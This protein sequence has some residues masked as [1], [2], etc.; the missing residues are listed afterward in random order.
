[1]RILIIHECDIRFAAFRYLNELVRKLQDRGDRVAV[2]CPHE[3]HFRLAGGAAPAFE[4]IPMAFEGPFLSRAAKRRIVEFAPDIVHPWNARQL[5][6]RAALEAVVATSAKLV[7]HYEDPEE[8]ILDHASAVVKA[9]NCLR[10]VNKPKLTGE[11]VE[12]FLREL[13]W[14]WI[15]STLGAPQAWNVV[16]PLFYALL[17]HLASAFTAIWHPLAALL[18]E[19]FDKPVALVPYG[20]DFAEP[21]QPRARRAG[22]IREELDLPPGCFVFLR[23]GTVYG[24]AHDQEILLAGFDRHRR[25][26]PESRLVICGRD[27][28]PATT[29]RVVHSLGLDEV[30]RTVG[31]LEDERFDALLADSDAAICPGHPDDFNHYRLSLKIISYMIERKPMICYASGIGGDLQDGRDALLLTEY[32]PAKVAELMDRLASDGALRCSLAQN[33]NQLARQWFDAGTLATRL[34]ALYERVLDP[35]AGAGQKDGL[36]PYL[37]M[38][39]IELFRHLQAGKVPADLKDEVQRLLGQ[40]LEAKGT[41]TSMYNLAT[42]LAREGRADEARTLLGQIVELA[43]PASRELA[44]KALYKLA[45]F[46]NDPIEAADLLSRCL[47]LYPEHRSARALLQRQHLADPLSRMQALLLVS[48]LAARGARYA[49]Y[50]PGELTARL[51]DILPRSGLPLPVAVLD[52]AAEGGA[53]LGGCRVVQ[54]KRLAAKAVDE[55]LLGQTPA[56]Q[57]GMVSL[58]RAGRQ[59][60]VVDVRD[61]PPDLNGSSKGMVAPTTVFHCSPHRAAS[62]WIRRLLSSPRVAAATGMTYFHY[63]EQWYGGLDPR[64]V[65]ERFFS[66]AFPTGAICGPMFVSVQGLRSIP[67]PR[68]WRAF[69]V[70]RDPRDLL[71]SLYFSDRYSHRLMG[72]LAE[73]RGR[74]GRLSVP[75]GIGLL[76]RE[77][78]TVGYFD[79]IRSWLDVPPGDPNILLVRYEELTGEA[80]VLAFRRLFDHLR[81]AVADGDLCQLL[82]ENSFEA[83]TGRTQ[84]QE[85]IYAHL[86]RGVP[87]D[88]RVYFDGECRRLFAEAAGD[89]PQAMGYE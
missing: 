40:S 18:E 71:V 7:V 64:P 67:K 63:E 80:G 10:W 47:Q 53:R 8:L 37:G 56:P 66:E 13:N 62:Q 1:M 26:F 84:G 22:R 54:P 36:G 12:A 70:L 61:L 30:V 24:H 57:G 33:A 9:S 41:L 5:E 88:W 38:E 76:I 42:L 25:N 39:S 55:V 73:L 11:D 83:L 68:E 27:Q 19:R 20:V 58:G 65:R 31:Y 85:D 81:L 59:V 28:E 44:G 50:G 75:E 2:L 14:P 43:G 6:A 16:H 48:R 72:N 79:A 52:G 77:W 23:A 4:T 69:Y 34:H 78:Q 21:P 86:R 60:R 87:G 49:I 3:D 32:S 17:N 46:T 89:L 15:L 82:T 74:L 51:L 35:S 29:R 45:T